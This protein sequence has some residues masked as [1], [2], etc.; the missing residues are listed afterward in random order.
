[1]GLLR[2]S[3]SRDNQAVLFYTL[4]AVLFVLFYLLLFPRPLPAEFTLVPS[5]AFPLGESKA[6]RLTSGGSFFVLGNW[7][8]YWNAQGQLERVSARRP[9][10]TASGERMAWYDSTKGQVAVEGPQGLL[11][12]IPGEQFP[13]WASQRLFTVDENRLGLK[14]YTANGHLQWAKHFSSILTAFDTS[15][16]LTV[17]GTLDGKVQVFGSLGNSIGGFQPGGSRLSVIYNVAVA[18]HDKAI[19]VL[20]GIDPKR[21]LVLERGGSEF[22]PVFHKALKENRPWPTPLGFLNDGSLAYYETEKGLA[23]LDP[24]SP[25]HEVVVQVTGSPVLLETLP[26][27]GLVAFVQRDGDRSVLRVAS[28][29]GVS[30]LTLPFLARDLLLKRQGDS[31]FLGTDQTLLRL[32]VHVQ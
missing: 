14:A 24:K 25:E 30:V 3:S 16:N 20:A 2:E 29:E 17:V 13:V 8:G 6:D 15:T 21:F 28:P 19:L 18:P 11:F 26:V 10:A 9:Q 12:T 1:M 5:Q 27:A 32:E 4:M 23:F 31:L 22:R 7:E